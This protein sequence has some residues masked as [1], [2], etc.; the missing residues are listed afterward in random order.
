MGM[1]YA[2]NMNDYLMNI[3]Q[4]PSFGSQL[5]GGLGYAGMWGMM[6]SSGAQNYAKL[7]AGGF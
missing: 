2:Q 5:A 4:M 6:S 1:D 3:A 7:M